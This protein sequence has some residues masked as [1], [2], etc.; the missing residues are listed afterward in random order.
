MSKFHMLISGLVSKIFPAAQ[1]VDE[2]V[3]LG[4]KISS[5]SPLIV[6]MCKDAVN[7]CIDINKLFINLINISIHFKNCIFF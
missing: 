6:R 4:E 1:L 7:K 3:K 2:A 5:H